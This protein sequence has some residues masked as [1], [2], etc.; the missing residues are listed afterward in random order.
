MED[1][2]ERELLNVVTPVKRSVEECL[3]CVCRRK[4][5]NFIW[6]TYKEV[7]PFLREKS[8]NSSLTCR[9]CNASY[10][11]I[12]YTPFSELFLSIGRQSPTKDVAFFC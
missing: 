4:S 11:K 3:R 9:V 6:R 12:S 1:E 7:L 2:S 10:E 8:M 5:K